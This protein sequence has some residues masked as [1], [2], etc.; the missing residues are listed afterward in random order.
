MSGVP[1]TKAIFCFNGFLTFPE[2]ALTFLVADDPMIVEV[3]LY[4]TVIFKT[5]VPAF[6]A[7]T[8]IPS[9]F[10]VFVNVLL[11]TLMTTF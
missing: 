3:P 7:K 5:P 1:L 11:P 8:T 4:V 6:G 2:I 10:V 9:A